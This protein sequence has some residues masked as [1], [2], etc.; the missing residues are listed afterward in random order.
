MSSERETDIRR[1][2]RH[3]GEFLVTRYPFF[4]A[5]CLA[6]VCSER[7]SKE[8]YEGFPREYIFIYCLSSLIVGSM[9]GSKTQR[10][11]FALIGSAIYM[12]HC[13]LTQTAH[14]D[15]N[16][17]LRARLISRDTALIGCN[18]V[19]ASRAHENLIRKYR[20]RNLFP[21]GC[22]ILALHIMFY[23]ALLFY[24]PE[25]KKAFLSHILLGNILLPLYMCIGVT[26]AILQMSNI[27]VSTT[28]M[29]IIVLHIILLFCI[30]C[31]FK[32]WT[33]RKVEYWTQ[34]EIVAKDCA[35]LGGLLLINYTSILKKRS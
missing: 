20:L 25:D 26:S 13:I 9:M 7:A 29:I 32:Y 23:I 4:S 21:T 1:F 15:M 31:D 34:V 10:S 6:L 11:L 14:I 18:F 28:S 19:L 12:V 22:Q 16:E 35:I 5:L 8:T 17:W 24:S 33:S 3:V 2:Q 27:K 30:D